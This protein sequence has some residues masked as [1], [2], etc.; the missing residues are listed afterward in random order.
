MGRNGSGVRAA[1]ETSI[2]ITFAYRGQRCRERIGLVPTAANLKAA[3]NH[4]GA[5]LDAIAKGTFDYAVTFPRSAKAKEFA[6]HIGDTETIEHYLERWF[7]KQKKH[8]KASTLRD[9]RQT[10]FNLLIPAFGKKH[11]TELKRGDVKAWCGQL[12]CGNKRIGNIIS[13]LRVALH[14]AMED[15]LIEFNPLSDW[16]YTNKEKPKLL[17]DVDPFTFDEQSAILSALKDPAARNQV[18]FSFWTGLRTSELVALE[19]G[20]IDWIRGTFRVNKALTQYSDEPEVPKTEAGKRDVK[21]LEPA[22]LAL[23]AQREISQLHPSGRIWLNPRTKEP[24]D[25]DQSIRKTLWIPALVAAKVRYRRPYQT[26]HTYASMMLSAGENPMW[27]ASQMGHSDWAEIR[28]T[29]GKWIKDSA[30]DAGNKAVA[31]FA[32]SVG[33]NAGINVGITMPK[34][35]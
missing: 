28:S 25:G 9:Y 12:T 8:I 31:T 20:D 18:Q 10:I 29:Y 32:P 35:A 26:R 11:L 19:W 3:E 15:E 30:P 34:T 23:K 22:L 24:W 33:Q 7:E 5:I 4:R 27:V 21:L 1:S 6:E 14:D 2:E 13:P 16:T 17:D